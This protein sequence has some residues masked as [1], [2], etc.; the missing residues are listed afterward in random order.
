MTEVVTNKL[1]SLHIALLAMPPNMTHLF[2]PLDLTVNGVAKKLLRKSLL[3]SWV[4]Q[5]L[6]PSEEIDV[7]LRLSNIK[8]L[9]A[10]WLV[11]TYTYFTSEDQE[12]IIKGWKKA[13][14][15]G[16]ADPFEAIYDSQ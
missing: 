10:Q 6:D 8:P 11:N 2:Q 9:H 7:D 4:Q 13:V 5:Q 1:S 3:S 15:V 14:V 16:P 12:S